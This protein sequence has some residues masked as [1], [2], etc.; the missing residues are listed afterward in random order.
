MK[1][2]LVLKDWDWFDHRRHT[3]GEQGIWEDITFTF[4][5]SEA[6]DYVVA[7][8]RLPVELTT[9]CSPEN[10]W[11]IMQEPPVP[12]YNWLHQGY[13]HFYRVFT[14]DIH[15]QGEKYIHTHGALPWWIS[16]T[17]DELKVLPP[18]DKTHKLSWITSNT[19]GRMGHR[20]RMTFL[21]QL[22]TQID[23]D[24]YGRG[25]QHVSDKWE[26]LS[27]YRYALAVENYSGPYYWTE[28]LMDVYLSW[29]MPIYHG[30]TNITD[31]FP[32]ESLV[33]IDIAKPDEAIAIIEETIHSDLW[34]KRREAIAYAR[35]LILDQY[36]FFPFITQKIHEW[37]Q[38]HPPTESQTIH[39]PKLPYLYP[40]KK[41]SV[42]SLQ[43]VFTAIKK[44]LQ[45]G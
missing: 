23:F 25:F 36:Q 28:K 21:R 17:Y 3:P 16:K 31:Y 37:E 24:L 11:A 6:C 22:R 15:L 14:P 45:R 20:Q 35:E 29:S 30:A 38:T 33:R 32:E 2:V 4:N 1:R 5:T 18:P 40:H 9:C 7:V 27:S 43:R 10:I 34:L 19:T 13:Q 26:A 41:Q 8:N 44:R 39:L 12:E 42:Y